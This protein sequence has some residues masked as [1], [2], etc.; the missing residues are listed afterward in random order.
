MS[1]TDRKSMSSRGKKGLAQEERLSQMVSCRVQ[2]ILEEEDETIQVRIIGVQKQDTLFSD[3]HFSMSDASAT[4][5]VDPNKANCFEASITYVKH[6]G[7][8]PYRALADSLA[9][10]IIDKIGV[11]LDESEG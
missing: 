5:E 1:P 6:K 9:E 10:E 2:R 11:L 3:M 8:R 7:F 4:V